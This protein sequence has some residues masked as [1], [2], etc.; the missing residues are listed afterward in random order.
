MRT[1]ILGPVQVLPELD[2]GL[3]RR[4]LLDG[5]F[6]KCYPLADTV[7]RPDAKE[8]VETLLRSETPVVVVTREYLAENG[9]ADR[10]S[11]NA[12]DFTKD[13]LPE[14]AKNTIRSAF[15]DA[16]LKD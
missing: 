12:C 8:V 5:L 4:A 7:F 2:Q 16:G 11:A 10:V 1:R 3:G 13:P 14:D 9:V 15:R 6:R